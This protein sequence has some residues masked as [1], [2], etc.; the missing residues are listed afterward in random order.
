MKN[1]F[2]CKYNSAQHIRAVM[3][4]SRGCEGGATVLLLP[5]VKE[6]KAGVWAMFEC[7]RACLTALKLDIKH[8]SL[9]PRIHKASCGVAFHQPLLCGF[10]GQTATLWEMEITNKKTKRNQLLALATD[11]QW[12]KQLSK[13][14]AEWTVCVVKA[15]SASGNDHL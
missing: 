8:G 13:E 6:I 10:R 7:A 1:V 3:W 15:L 2:Q 4:K 11:F 9:S 5:E 14:S 12:T